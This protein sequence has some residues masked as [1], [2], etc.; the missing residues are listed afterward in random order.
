MRLN[1]LRFHFKLQKTEIFAFKIHNTCH[2]F[3]TEV[4]F[5]KVEDAGD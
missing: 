2:V 4:P 3:V 5:A 1:A